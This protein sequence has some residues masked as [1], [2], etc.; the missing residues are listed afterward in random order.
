MLC[1]Y[2]KGIECIKHHN[3]QAL[4][5]TANLILG[6]INYRYKPSVSIAI[7]HV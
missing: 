2:K 6:T 5:H 1:I 4:P 3:R 7:C